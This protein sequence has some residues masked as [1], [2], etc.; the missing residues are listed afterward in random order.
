MV[1]S[2]K[3]HYIPRFYLNGFTNENAGYFIFDKEKEEIRYTNPINSFFKNNRNS[4]IVNG[5]KLTIFQGS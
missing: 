4:V 3:H 1:A 5:E 2:K